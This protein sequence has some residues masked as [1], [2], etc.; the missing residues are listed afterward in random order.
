M[1]DAEFVLERLEERSHTTMDLINA[2]YAELGHGLTPHSRVADLRRQ[3]HDIRCLR[4]PVGGKRPVYQYM[5][6]RDPVQLELIA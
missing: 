5:L 4:L 3:G 1:T 2:A 6:V